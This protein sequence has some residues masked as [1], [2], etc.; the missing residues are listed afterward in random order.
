MLHKSPIAYRI[1]THIPSIMMNISSTGGWG[2]EYLFKTS[3]KMSWL[4]PTTVI[5]NDSML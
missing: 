1:T 2:D 3:V 4:Y 5:S